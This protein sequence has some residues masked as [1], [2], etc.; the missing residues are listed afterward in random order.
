MIDF[1]TKAVKLSANLVVRFLICVRQWLSDG[2]VTFVWQL[3][4]TV[5]SR[6]VKVLMIFYLSTLLMRIIIM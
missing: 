1:S 3:L 4:E 5:G 2:A 6:I